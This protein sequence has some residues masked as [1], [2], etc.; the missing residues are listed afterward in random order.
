MIHGFEKETEELRPH[1]VKTAHIIAMMLQN[2]EGKASSITALRISD[3]LEKNFGLNVDDARI[4]KMIAYIKKRNLVPGLIANSR[5]YFWTED[6]EE[7]EKYVHGCYSRMYAIKEMAD[8]YGFDPYQLKI[9]Y[10]T[11]R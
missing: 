8:S 6:R 3:V 5:G 9:K 7:I 11:H 10:D 4:R 1:E 2:H